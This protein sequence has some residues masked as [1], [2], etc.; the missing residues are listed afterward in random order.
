MAKGKKT[1]GKNFEP[2]VSNNPS[3][4]P[5]L[6]VWVREAKKLTAESFLL[7]LHEMHD[8]PHETLEE[9]S[10]DKSLPIKSIIMA[11]W[12]LG[13][14]T[15]DNE[16]QNLFNRLFGKVTE[17]VEVR[18]PVPTIIRRRNGEEIILGAALQKGTDE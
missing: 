18:M 1:G 10:K 16:R 17:S 8:L 14:T 6:P 5:A 2:G 3:G 13:S 15:Q 12:L 4:R 11:N 9:I 7:C